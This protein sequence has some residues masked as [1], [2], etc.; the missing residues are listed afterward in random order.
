MASVR[1]WVLKMDVTWST[2][3]V[4]KVATA[5]AF[6]TRNTLNKYSNCLACQSVNSFLYFLKQSPECSYSLR[7]LHVCA[8]P[9]QLYLIYIDRAEPLLI[10][11][12]FLCFLDLIFTSFVYFSAFSTV[13]FFFREIGGKPEVSGNFTGFTLISCCSLVAGVGVGA[14]TDCY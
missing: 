10:V 8:Y 13:F 7:A 12:L 9:I 14:V 1:G 5:W 3:V 4:P 11:L 6:L 2:A